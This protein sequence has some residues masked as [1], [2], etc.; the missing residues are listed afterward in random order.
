MISLRGSLLLARTP[1][2]FKVTGQKFANCE[3]LCRRSFLQA[4]V[5]GMGGLALSDFLR[6]RANAGTPGVS[7]D[8]S[9]ILFWMSG[10]PGHMETW[11]PKPDAVDRYRGPF[12]AISTNIAGIQFGEL[13]PEQAKLMDRVAVLRSVNHGS[14]DHTKGNHWMLTGFEGPDF[15]APDNKVQRRPCLGS[16]VSVLRGANRPGL[17]PY[18]AAP[19]LRGG[20]DNFFHY[21]AYLGGGANPFIVN[22]DPNAASFRVQNLALNGDISFDR[23]E[24]RRELLGALDRFTREGERRAA[25]MNEHQQHAFQLL[26]SKSVR[27]AF[28]I[29][30]EPSATRDAYGRHTFGQSAV[31]ARR[32]IEGGVTFVTVNCEPWDHH[33]TSGRLKTE[34]GAKKLIPPFDTAIAAL[35]RDLIDRGLYDNTLVVAMGEFGRTPK[36][37]S[38]GGRDHWGHTFS[39]LMG[40]GSMRMGQVIGKS[41]PRGERVA[42]RPISPQD[43]AATIYHHLGI[44]ASS[45]TFPD[46]NGRPMYLVEHGDPIRGLVG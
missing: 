21:A 29:S 24:N 35:I 41:T 19:H 34:E 5:L 43:V 25:D 27:D 2:M 40:C 45:I 10:G 3:G 46:R 18:V 30:Q 31:L 13:M 14:G 7:R 6:L 12:G 39:A 17:P 32:L 9:V 38:D 16:A 8:T 4:G 33:G 15:N 37:N 42:D 1:A 44:D 36:M 20:T 23:L 26:T 28:D 22:S 11:D